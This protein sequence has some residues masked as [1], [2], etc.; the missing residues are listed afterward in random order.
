MH[1]MFEYRLSTGAIAST[2]ADS[3]LEDEQAMNTRRLLHAAATS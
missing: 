3:R 1:G 2:I